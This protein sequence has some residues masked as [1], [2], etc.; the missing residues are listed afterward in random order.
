MPGL[1][2]RVSLSVAS[3]SRE[4]PIHIWDAFTGE[5]RASFRA[6][7]HLVPTSLPSPC[8]HCNPAFLFGRQL[9]LRRPVCSPLL[10]LG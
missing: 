1:S 10:P 4:N 7:N 6:Y 8:A 5:L 2:V 9:K 3:S